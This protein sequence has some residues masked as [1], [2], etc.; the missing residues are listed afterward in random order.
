MTRRIPW[1]RPTDWRVPVSSA[2]P[3]R[4]KRKTTAL[5]WASAASTRSASEGFGLGAGCG[6]VGLVEVLG[7]AT[8][9]A[10]L[11][12]AASATAGAPA[13]VGAASCFGATG[14]G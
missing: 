7:P 5:P 8:A 9:Y 3:G 11:V 1:S 6:A 2:A 13:F 14:F 10:P 4:V 12:T